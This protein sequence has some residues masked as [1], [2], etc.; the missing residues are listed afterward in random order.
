M[1]CAHSGAARLSCAFRRKQLLA[2]RRGSVC[3]QG[4]QAARCQLHCARV[5]KRSVHAGA[6][7]CPLP[8]ARAPCGRRD[9]MLTVPSAPGP[10]VYQRLTTMQLPSLI[11]PMA[12]R[13]EQDVSR[14]GRPPHTGGK[15]ASHAPVPPE[16]LNTLA[17]PWKEPPPVKVRARTM[18]LARKCWGGR[19]GGGRAWL[20]GCDR[21]RTDARGG[22]LCVGLC[23]RV[24]ECVRGRTEGRMC[25]PSVCVCVCVCIC[26]HVCARARIPGAVRVAAKAGRACFQLTVCLQWCFAWI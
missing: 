7:S 2:K 21:V 9:S 8:N 4:Q 16:P 17:P 20:C 24:R 3:M 12:A 26:V 25:V 19:A 5:R 1:R 6:A 13:D 23:V 11:N 14:H 18:L 10:G 22:L 15:G